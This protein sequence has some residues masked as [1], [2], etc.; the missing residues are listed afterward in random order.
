M[1]KIAH[2][3]RHFLPRGVITNDNY[4]SGSNGTCKVITDT[5]PDTQDCINRKEMG[6]SELWFLV[7]CRERTRGDVEGDA[8]RT[9]QPCHTQKIAPLSWE[10]F[11]FLLDDP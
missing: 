7:S 8:G 4:G 10:A 2:F 5:D 6:R 3:Y 11:Y 9:S 1:S